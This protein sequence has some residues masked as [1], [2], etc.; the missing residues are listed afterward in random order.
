MLDNL[1]NTSKDMEILCKSE[2]ID[3]LMDI[4]DATI[5]FNRIFNDTNMLHF[6][7]LP[8]VDEKRRNL[9]VPVPFSNLFDFTSNLRYT[10]SPRSVFTQLNG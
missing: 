8:L 7:Y 5:F 6:Y 9:V 1:I 4:E 10:K 3:N 2:I